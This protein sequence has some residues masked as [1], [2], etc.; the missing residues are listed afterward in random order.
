MLRG[1]RPA[2]L[3]VL[4][5][6]VAIGFGVPAVVGAEPASRPSS[7][8]AGGL[9]VGRYHACALLV[10]ATVRCWGYG[11]DGALGYAAT[12]SIGD[13]ETP[14]AAGPVDL[15]AARVR[16]LSAGAVH[17]CAVLDDATVRCWGFGGDGRLGYGNANNIGDDEGP[18]AAGPVNLGAG[19]T[20]RAITAG[21]AHTCA[22]LDDGSVRCWGFGFDGRLGYGHTNSIGDDEVP[23]AVSPVNLGA[24]RTARA[25][26]AGDSHTCALLDDATVRCWGYAGNGQLG[27]GNTTTFSETQTPDSAGPVNLGAGRTAVAISAGS[28]HTCAVLDDGTV[29]CWGFGG[30]G[31]LGYA[32]TNGVGDDETPGSVGPVNLGAG[33]TAVAISAGGEHTCAV[34]D[35]GTVRC[36]GAGRSGRLGYANTNDIGDDETPGSVGPVDLGPGRTAVAISAGSDST[37]A[38]L[39]DGSVRCWGDGANGLLGTCNTNSVGDDETPGSVGPIALEGGSSPGA[40]CLAAAPPAGPAAGGPGAPG[41]VPG[42]PPPAGAARAADKDGLAAQSAR[43]RGLRA[44]RSAV[45]LRARLQRRR[46]PSRSGH[47]RAVAVR[48][49]AG[50]ASRARRAC[51]ERYAR[52]PGRVTALHARPSGRHG[53]TLTFRAAGTYGTKPPPARRYLV[54]QSLRPIRTA[55]EFRRAHALCKG[56][57]AFDVT[58]IGAPISLNVTDLRPRRTYYYAVAARDNVSA[59]SGPRAGTVRASAR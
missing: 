13:D 4:A 59:V 17:T 15:G 56:A 23:G 7:A 55:A 43:A 33:R 58:R 21:R 27:Y 38:R 12:T 16:A 10:T 9:D 1:T 42:A 53:I 54:K 5:A 41:P 39:D 47:A 30:N 25:I 51:L 32:N 22:V 46:V 31:R 44:C 11:A 2:V 52:I 36:W 18:G 40:G 6:A 45:S 14:A 20:A 50:R 28:F 3:R 19:R 8:A 37:C 48:R 35:N 57:C 49:I 24:G 29:R 34:L 26:T